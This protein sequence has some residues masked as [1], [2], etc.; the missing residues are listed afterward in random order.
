M[1]LQSS[2]TYIILDPLDPLIR[3]PANRTEI[4]GGASRGAARAPQSAG[5]QTDAAAGKALRQPLA[6]GG[7][8]ACSE[9]SPSP[10]SPL[11]GVPGRSLR[12]G[13]TDRP[14]M[15]MRNHF[16]AKSNLYLPCNETYPTCEMQSKC[17]KPLSIGVQVQDC[18]FEIHIWQD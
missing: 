5:S 12:P 13:T 10:G 3:P 6:G 1:Y 11:C 18:S 15:R 2:Y 7:A 17:F 9:G 14:G 4:A 16:C 8:G